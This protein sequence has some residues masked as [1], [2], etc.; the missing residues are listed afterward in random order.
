[1]KTLKK[2]LCAVTA[3]IVAISFA[4]C[5][6]TDASVGESSSQP[7]ES[8]STSGGTKYD[9]A[10]RPAGKKIVIYCGGSSEYSVVKGTEE[11][12]VKKA[13]EDAYYADTGISLDLD[14]QYLGT[15]MQSVLANSLVAHDQVDIVVSHTRFD[16]GIDD[17]T[18]GQGIY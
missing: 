15:N 17:Y 2:I 6:K 5:G 4:A 9:P 1:M 14:V 16:S 10:T 8:N 7:I 18:I 11:K 13:V 3:M 12:V